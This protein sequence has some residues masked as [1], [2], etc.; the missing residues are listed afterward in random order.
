MLGSLDC[1]VEA[2]GRTLAGSGG[3]GQRN[4]LAGLAKPIMPPPRRRERPR[5]PFGAG[6]DSPWRET[7]PIR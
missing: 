3:D 4:R 6:L 1:A 5:R 2:L 7:G